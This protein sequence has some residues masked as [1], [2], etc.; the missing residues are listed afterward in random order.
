MIWFPRQFCPECGGDKV[1]WLEASGR[2]TI[3]SFTVTRNGS[4]S[5]KDAAPYVLAFV[6]LEEG[7]R[8]M[9]NIVDCDPATVTIDMAVH[10]VW[11]DIGDGHALYRFAPST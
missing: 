1:S 10:V 8:V 9:T 5:W 3:Y 2:G 7:P 11:D 4:G 6:D